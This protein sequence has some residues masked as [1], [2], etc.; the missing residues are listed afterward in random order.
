[1]YRANWPHRCI[2]PNILRRF[3]IY[4]PQTSPPN[5]RGR[6]LLK[7]FCEAYITLILSKPVKDT[8]HTKFQVS[9]TDECSCK[10][11]QHNI[12]KLNQQY[13]KRIINNDQ[14]WFIPG[15]QRCFNICKSSNVIYHLA[16]WTVNVIYH[17]NKCRKSFLTKFNI[18]LLI[19][20]L[21]K[22][23]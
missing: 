20:T 6:I 14:V 19:K 7:S 16:N 3:N 9:V 2:I 11:P 17:L 22:C 15:M 18:Y 1:M 5:C 13:S 12:S 4:L 21:K 10:N 8:T 23:M